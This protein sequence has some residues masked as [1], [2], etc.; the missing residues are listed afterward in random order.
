MIA[1]ESSDRGLH[2]TKRIM[3]VETRVED[4]VTL[5]LFIDASERSI[6]C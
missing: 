6:L 3:T 4:E 2:E 1:N 5:I